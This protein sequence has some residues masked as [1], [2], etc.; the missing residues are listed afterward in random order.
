MGTTTAQRT[1]TNRPTV[2][3]VMAIMAMLVFAI[4]AAG[5][6]PRATAAPD[7]VTLELAPASTAIVHGAVTT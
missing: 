3:G 7:P 2:D 4:L 5:A 6:A 1:G